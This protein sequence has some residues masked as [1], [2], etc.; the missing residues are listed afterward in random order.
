MKLGAFGSTTERKTFWLPVKQGPGPGK[1]DDGLS[2][3]EGTTDLAI[4]GID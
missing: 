4:L 1:Y 2:L 3:A